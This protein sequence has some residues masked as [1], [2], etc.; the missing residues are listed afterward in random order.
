MS[1]KVLDQC[2]VW[3]AKN[4]ESM[5]TSGLRVLLQELCQL[6]DLEIS[7][8]CESFGGVEA[9]GLQLVP[10]M[11]WL[12]RL[13]GPP[14]AP[15]QSGVPL[16]EF[17]R[18]VTEHEEWLSTAR[19][20]PVTHCSCRPNM[21]DV[22]A[23]ILKPRTK[24]R[25]VAY[26]EL[27]EPLA[28]NVF[29]S[30]WWGEEFICFVT[31]LRLFASVYVSQTH[32]FDQASFDVVLKQDDEKDVSFWVCSFANR[33]WEVNLGNTL[34]ESPFER[35]LSSPCCTHVVMIMDPAATPLCRIWCLSL[36]STLS[37][38]F[39]CLLENQRAVAKSTLRRAASKHKIIHFF[40]NTARL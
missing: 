5:Q 38:D 11:R 9:E 33:Q 12:L 31:A 8:L 7:L 10:F 2:D 24:A 13:P 27:L 23:R 39:N 34:Q 22:V 28:P 19:W 26:A 14:R 36:T 15:E 18:L 29:V 37:E 40:G 4:G 25:Q 21:Y 6:S 32:S 16:R 1:E 30:H 3:A 35:A 20:N 17:M